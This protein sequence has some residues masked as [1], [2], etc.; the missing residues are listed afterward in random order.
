MRFVDVNV[1]VSAH[2]PESPDH[3]GFRAWLDEARTADEPLGLGDL[4][5]SGFLRVVTHPRVFKTPTPLDVAV[6]FVAALRS[7]PNVVRMLPGDRHFNIFLRL[8]RDIGA[9]GNDVPDLYLAALAI[10]TGSTLWSADR[11]FARVPDLHW[12]HPLDGS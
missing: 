9:R 2:R 3:A 7:T 4:V 8:C 10:E 1:L 5:L 11:S 6:E 12:R